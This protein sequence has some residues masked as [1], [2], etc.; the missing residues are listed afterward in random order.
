[1]ADSAQELTAFGRYR[2]V[3]QLGEG[4]MAVVHR[5]VVQ[6]PEGFERQV[7]VKRILPELARYPEFTKMLLAEARLCGLLH[8]P[9][10]VQVNEVGEVDGQYYLAMEYVDGVDLATVMKR[11][12]EL[13]RPMPEGLAC[14]VA[15][16]LADALAYAHA[17]TG[18]DGRPLE[19][20]HRDVSPSNVMLTRQGGV[21]LLDFGIAKA[22]SQVRDE[23]TRTGT[24][25]GKLSYMSPEQADG[26]P[27]DRRSDLFALGIVLYECLTVERLFRGGDDLETLR[28]V[29]EAKV[30]PP[31][32]V[33][34]E[35]SPDVDAVVVKLLARLPEARYQTGADAAAALR[36]I[37]HKHQADASAVRAFLESLGPLGEARPA[38][39]GSEATTPAH[40][41]AMATPATQP[42]PAGTTI[43]IPPTRVHTDGKTATRRL[44]P[45][46]VLGGLAVIALATVAVL[47]WRGPRIRISSSSSIEFGKPKDTVPALVPA[48]E[49]SHAPRSGPLRVAVVQFKN[50]GGDK[51]LEFL[52]EG[53]GDTI[54]TQLGRQHDRVRLVERNQVEKALKEIDLGQTKYADKQTAAA[55]GRVTGAELVILGGF[56]RTE[57]Q[58]RVS[59]RF[60]GAESGEVIDSFDLTRP[61][62][63]LLGVEDAVAAELPPRLLAQA[64]R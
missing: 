34:P 6:G 30:W 26:L 18:S 13:G 31:S 20:V 17:L 63:G 11:S 59:V 40:A 28:K 23:R 1:M 55:L 12:S 37:A 39:T 44:P 58:I 41:R 60:V 43:P 53:I 27:I 42:T 57:G 29:R 48:A 25:K 16:E 35:L 47:A 45:R 21:K 9:G 50:L 64:K 52:S 19:I 5:A 32:S 7:V 10:I 14:F 46:A 38:P 15:A 2:L 3:G 49:A 33:R 54:A 24:L 61:A 56:Q 36:P 22:K 4:G 8:H 51:D 62:S